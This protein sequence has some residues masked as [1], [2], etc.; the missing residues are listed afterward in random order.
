MNELQMQ[1]YSSNL[2][3]LQNKEHELQ[4]K[5]TIFTVGLISYASEYLYKEY[6]MPSWVTTKGLRRMKHP[7]Q[8]N[9]FVTVNG[10]ECPYT[11][12]TLKVFILSGATCFS[13]S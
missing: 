6:R 8:L 3:I 9:F 12:L 4:I 7:C 13:K 10:S 5:K 2:M 11:R 1:G